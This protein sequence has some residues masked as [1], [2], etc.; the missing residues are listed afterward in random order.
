MKFTEHEMVFFNSITNGNS[1]LGIPL[2]FRPEKD[3]DTEVQKTLQGLIKK[4]F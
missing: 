2:N 1:V 3:Y 4:V